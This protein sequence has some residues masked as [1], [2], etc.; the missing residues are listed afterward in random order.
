MG[1]AKQQGSSTARYNRWRLGH[2][3]GDG[4]FWS[5]GPLAPK[6]GSREAQD[7]LQG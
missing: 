7:G 2:Q 3:G 1:L 6:P 5:R 4:G